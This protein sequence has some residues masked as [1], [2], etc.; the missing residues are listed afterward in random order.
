MSLLERWFG[1]KRS[2]FFIEPVRFSNLSEKIQSLKV[3]DVHWVQQIP[4]EIPPDSPRDLRGTWEGVSLRHPWTYHLEWCPG[5]WAI[6][7]SF[8][9]M[10]RK[11][12]RWV[13]HG[14]KV[15]GEERF[16]FYYPVGSELFLKRDDLMSYCE[17]I[18]MMERCPETEQALRNWYS[19]TMTTSPMRYTLLE[20]EFVTAYESLYKSVSNFFLKVEG[21]YSHVWGPAAGNR[22]LRPTEENIDLK[23]ELYREAFINRLHFLLDYLPERKGKNATL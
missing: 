3:T 4:Y 23:R 2:F 14:M 9:R 22:Y 6:S 16:R 15:S 17:I 5:G 1:I 8:N 12:L 13:E 21:L 19:T 7:I 11:N 10:I 18:D 20:P